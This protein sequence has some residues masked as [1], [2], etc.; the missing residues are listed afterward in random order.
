MH[1]QVTRMVTAWLEHDTYGVNAL[2]PVI[3]RLKL[4]GSED[5]E[6]PEVSV[7]N[8]VDFTV[9]ESAVGIVPPSTPSIVVVSDGTSRDV[10]S[11][12]PVKP[13]HKLE[14]WLVAVGYYA[15]PGYREEAIVAGDYT[16]RAISQSLQRLHGQRAKEYR[17]LNGVMIARITQIDI[18]RVAPGV[19]QSTLLGL[20]FAQLTILNKLP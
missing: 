17:E 10:E 5:P 12:Q 11:G 6:P 3:P 9:V 18:E 20:V 4:D 7:F 1:V 2:L 19:P 13:G 14:D 15:E 8:D 16:M